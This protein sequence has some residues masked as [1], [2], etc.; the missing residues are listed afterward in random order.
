MRIDDTS[1]PL[2]YGR[3]PLYPELTGV[4]HLTDVRRAFRRISSWATRDSPESKGNGRRTSS[5]SQAVPGRRAL[6]HQSEF[7]GKLCDRG[8]PMSR[9]AMRSRAFSVLV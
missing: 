3:T 6:D 8:A 2:V 4:E 7:H 1:K 9:N 5:L